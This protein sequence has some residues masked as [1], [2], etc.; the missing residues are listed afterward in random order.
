MTFALLGAVVTLL[1]LLPSQQWWV[2]MWDFPRIQILGW[3][4]FTALL[5]ALFVRP[6]RPLG[7]ALLVSQLF[8]I[9]Y[10]SFRIYPY[11]VLHAVQV[12]AIEP[13]TTGDTV[14][15]LT[16]NVLMSNTDSERLLALI[17]AEKPDLVLLTEPNTWW[18]EQ[19]VS[20]KEEYPFAVLHP[21]E[22]TY[23]IALY[24]RL[25]LK[26]TQVQFLVESDIP[27]IHTVFTLGSG[28][29][30]PP[31]LSFKNSVALSIL[32]SDEASSIPF[33]PIIPS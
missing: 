20:I 11:T 22:N 16:A 21:L 30:L 1:P 12:E 9:G 3:C 28:R 15:I 31:Q 2:R 19:L 10:Q 5:L 17:R 18:V 6:F 13:N 25:P 24:S 27:S 23:G 4:A 8:C 33:T 26:E 29:G 14:T 32:E 7:L